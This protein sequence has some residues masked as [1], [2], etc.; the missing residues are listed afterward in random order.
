MKRFTTR[1]GIVVLGAVAVAAVAAAGAYAWF[2]STGTGTGSAT[3][4]TSTAWTVGQ[5]ATSGG[6]LY[7]NATIGTG[8]I[9]TKTYHVKN[10]S[11]GNQKL[12]QVSISVAN[13][14]GSAWSA[15][16]A[17]HPNCTAADFSVGGEAVGVAHV[18]T[19]LAGTFTPNQD[20]TTGS[21]TVQ[22][23]DNTAD[24]DACKSVT[25]PLYFAA[26]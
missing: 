22:M 4:G 11:T 23:I 2:S 15:T 19:G 20:K 1:K 21:V 8:D 26:S 12:T 7:P 16:S 10:T 24:Q 3:V 6:L 9:Q 17:G 25:P 5:T 18:D 14:D 13:S